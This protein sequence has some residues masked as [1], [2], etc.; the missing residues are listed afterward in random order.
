MGCAPW[1]LLILLQE[2]RTLLGKLE[3]QRG[4]LA[5]ALCVVEGTDLQAAIQQ[6]QSLVSER[7]AAKKARPRETG[8]NISRHVSSL[9]LESIYIKAKTL[10]KQ[11]KIN[12]I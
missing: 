5:G 10:R 7:S 2:A 12:G 8:E 9:M 11:G 1:L 3:Y 4:N 6:L